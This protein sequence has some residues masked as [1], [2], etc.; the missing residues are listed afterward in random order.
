MFHILCVM[1]A[2]KTVN[3]QFYTAFST[4]INTKNC[5]KS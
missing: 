3:D 4:E 5:N 1:D 2:K